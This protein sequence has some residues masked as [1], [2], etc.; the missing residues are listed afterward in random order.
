MNDRVSLAQDRVAAETRAAVKAKVEAEVERAQASEQKARERLAALEIRNGQ[1]AGE[2]EFL[3]GRLD[4]GNGSEPEP[5]A[6]KPEPEPSKPKRERRMRRKHFE[7]DPAGM[8]RTE[9]SDGTLVYEL[10]TGT[11][12]WES[13]GPDREVA[14]ERL[15]ELTGEEER[16]ASRPKRSKPPGPTGNLRPEEV[17]IS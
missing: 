5:E 3:R 13:A 2:N 10:K 9:L 1:L 16:K 7:E 17:G 12:P 14:I 6:S 8:Y 15:R 4:H 11:A